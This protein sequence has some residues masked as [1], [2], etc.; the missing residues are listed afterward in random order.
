MRKRLTQFFL[1]AFVCIIVNFGA[2]MTVCA[3]NKGFDSMKS[4]YGHWQEDGYPDDVGGVY[5]SNEK[6]VVL[7]VNMD[8]SRVDELKKSLSDPSN[9][10]F[11]NCNYSYN[12]LKALCSQLDSHIW[13]SEDVY[14]LGVDIKGNCVSIGVNTAAVS[15]YEN[16]YTATYGDKIN[17]FAD[18]QNVADKQPF[19][20]LPF[21]GICAV[22][23]MIVLAIVLSLGKIRN[24]S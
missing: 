12:E 15:K 22:A 18:E 7:F 21:V 13:S 2:Y 9:V 6:Y 23:V 17:V 10:E 11:E 5:L 3:E 24:R 4:L 8:A 16:K 1:V 19:N 20:M 14:S